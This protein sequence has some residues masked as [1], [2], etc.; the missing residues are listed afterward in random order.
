MNE[1][2]VQALAPPR[3]LQGTGGCLLVPTEDTS[4]TL[5]KCPAPQ[6]AEYCSLVPSRV[7]KT[8]N[9]GTHGSEMESVGAEP[10]VGQER[11]GDPLA[12]SQVL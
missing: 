7:Q 1:R 3:F 6:E 9:L 8:Q 11:E 2:D 5:G 12:T 4:G 10:W